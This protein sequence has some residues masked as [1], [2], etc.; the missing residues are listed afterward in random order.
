MKSILSIEEDNGNRFIKCNSA[1]YFWRKQYDYN[2][3]IAS[4]CSTR[5]WDKV[6]N[7]SPKETEAVIEEIAESHKKLYDEVLRR[8]SINI[9]SLFMAMLSLRY[10]NHI[11]ECSKFL[12]T[13]EKRENN[14]DKKYSYVQVTF[15]LYDSDGNQLKVLRKGKILI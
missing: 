5:Y 3:K 2:E 1:I 4:D 8:K 11:K 15:N 10:I 9:D 6:F 14:T 7:F 12:I 13:A